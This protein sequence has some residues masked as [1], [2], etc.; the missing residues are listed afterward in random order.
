MN[1]QLAVAWSL[2]RASSRAGFFPIGHSGLHDTHL[3]NTIGQALS[4]LST[5]FD[6][7]HIEPVAVFW[8]AVEFQAIEQP[9]C[10]VRLEGFVDHSADAVSVGGW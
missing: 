1:C 5:Q 8:R 10:F 7:C 6:L 3:V 2:L 9:P 4:R